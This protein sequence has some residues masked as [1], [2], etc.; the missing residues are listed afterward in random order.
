M[1]E[2]IQLLRIEHHQI[3]ELLRSVEN[4]IDSAAA[5][6]LELMQSIADYFAGYPDQCHHPVEDLVFRKL[7][8]REPA[9]AAEVV[10]T[11]K[12]HRTISE[13][14][15]KLTAAV[16]EASSDGD[17]TAL[18]TVMRE[19]VDR[20]RAHMDSEES[21]FFPLALRV[22]KDEDW[23]EVEYQLFDRQDPLYDRDIEDRFRRLREEIEKRAAES[24]RRGA[25]MREAQILRRFD[26]ISAFNDEMARTGRDYCLIEHPEGSFGLEKNGSCVIDIPRCSPARAAWCAYFYIAGLTEK[27]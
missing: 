9:R 25:F 23:A 18:R 26:G 24:F 14:T 1:T 21:E 3:N 16:K 20:Y 10:E 19:F 15:G 17:Q 2:A 12:D 11:L 7:E 6:D 13:I 4:E 8:K 27:A 22:L 5:V